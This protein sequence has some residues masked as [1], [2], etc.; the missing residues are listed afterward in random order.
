MTPAGKG[1]SSHEEANHECVV[2]PRSNEKEQ[3]QWVQDPEGQGGSRVSSI[4]S[5][6]RRKADSNER[7]ARHR[8]EAQEN[9]RKKNSVTR[10]LDGAT[11]ERAEERAVG[12]G[13]LIQIPCAREANGVAP[14]TPGP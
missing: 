7:D 3:D 6:Q 4:T 13:V 14:S 1:E 8:Q 9:N 10:K 2:V 11:L 12:E 5:R